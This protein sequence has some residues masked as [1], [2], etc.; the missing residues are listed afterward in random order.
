MFG[1]T[2]CTC[3]YCDLVVEMTCTVLFYWKVPR[4]VELLLTWHLKYFINAGIV[5]EIL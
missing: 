2:S 3:T 5:L 1:T 4:T